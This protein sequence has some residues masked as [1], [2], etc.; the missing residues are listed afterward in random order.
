MG[1]IDLLLLTVWTQAQEVRQHWLDGHQ[2]CSQLSTTVKPNQVSVT[3]LP[4]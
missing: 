1:S 3:L 4:S 2:G